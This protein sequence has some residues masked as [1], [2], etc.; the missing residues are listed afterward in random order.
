M[1][2]ITVKEGELVLRD[3]RIALLVSRFNSFVVESLLAGAID[4]LKRHGCEEGDLETQRPGP[5]QG[6]AEVVEGHRAAPAL[7][8]LVVMLEPLQLTHLTDNEVMMITTAAKAGKEH[9]IQHGGNTQ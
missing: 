5:L 4:T 2:D 9:C 6:E 8:G 1:N 3:A 7:N